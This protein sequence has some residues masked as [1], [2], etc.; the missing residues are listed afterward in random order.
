MTEREFNITIT[1]IRGSLVRFAAG[2][3]VEGALTP[4][5]MVQESIARIW[6]LNCEGMEFNSTEAI[7][8]KIIK[9]VCLDYI[10]LKKNNNKS[11]EERDSINVQHEQTPEKI[12][13]RKESFNM[14]VGYI[15]KLTPE[16]QVVIRLRD[17]MGYE[18]DEIAQIVGATEGNTRVL[19]SRARKKLRDLLLN[20]I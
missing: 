5:D 6:R 18:L 13:E 16:Q 19:L 9:N 10:K 4:E 11:I 20:E 1:K 8:K 14:I 17:V 12:L 2:F 15:S 3:S 7:S